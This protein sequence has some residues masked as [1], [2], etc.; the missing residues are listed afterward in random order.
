MAEN[1]HAD[2]AS[3]GG[4]EELGKK[5]AE[6]AGGATV[7]SVGR[8]RLIAAAVGSVTTVVPGVAINRG[9]LESSGRRRWWWRGGGLLM[10]ATAARPVVI[11]LLARVGRR[12]RLAWWLVPGRLRA[13]GG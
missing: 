1:N 10:V 11:G 9:L 7:G 6:L 8:C 12:L 2:A 3:T 4:R 5:A 13:G